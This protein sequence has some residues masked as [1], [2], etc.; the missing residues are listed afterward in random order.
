MKVNPLI[1][2]QYDIRGVVD[3]DLNEEFVEALGRAIGTYMRRHDAR[4]LVVGYDVRLSSEPYSHALIR[5]LRSTGCNVTSVGC[6]PT[7]VLYFSIVYYEK[8]GGVMIT[9]SHNPIEYN[10]FKICMG[11]ESVYGEQIQVLRKIMEEED[12]I[13]D[14][15]GELKREDPTEAYIKAIRERIKLGGKRLKIV[16]DAGNGTAGPIATRLFEELGLEVLPLYCEPDGRFP[17]HLPDPTVE[18]Y[19]VD[20]RKKVCEVGADCG[21]GYDGDADRIGAVDEKGEIVWGDKLLGI[22][23]KDVLR[24][25]RAKIIF[26]VKCSQ[27]LVEYIESNGGI[28]LMWK[29]GHSMIKA[30]MRQ[31]G[32]PLA[33]EMSGHMFFADN[34]YGYDDAIF[35]SARLVQILSN[36]DMSLSQLASQMPTYPSTPEIRVKCDDEKKFQLVEDVKNYF[37]SKYEVIDVDGVRVLFPDGWG[38]LRASNTQP[39]IVL[40]FEAKTREALQRIREEF[41]GRLREAG[42]ICDEAIKA[43]LEV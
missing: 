21:I 34:Y 10:G 8:D 6:V 15:K 41:V 36:A 18:K 20:L 5:G 1:F 43:I 2:R 33:G 3:K 17:N 29:T 39:V 32:A 22:F 38:L 40:R 14:A 30:K 12:F 24:K 23:A 4:N 37:A 11:L 28:P 42:A 9:G 13:E 27:A 26:D 7:P 19:T 25:G 35:A 16:I 31:E